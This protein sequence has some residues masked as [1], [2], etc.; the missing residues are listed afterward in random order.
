M[1]ETKGMTKDEYRQQW[2]TLKARIRYKEASIAQWKRHLEDG[3]FP[4]QVPTFKPYPKLDTPNS[5]AIVNAACH[6]A[7]KTI[8]MEML[9]C[10]ECKL[11]QD[12]GDLETLVKERREQR[13]QERLKTKKGDSV[14][15]QLQQQ[16]KELQA[17]FD[18]S[19]K[20]GCPWAIEQTLVM[21]NKH[22][23]GWC[24]TLDFTLLLLWLK[25]RVDA[26]KQPYSK[27]LENFVLC[28][29]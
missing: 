12:Y 17:K 26:T 11:A 10:T 13:K 23:I 29:L 8:L 3:T 14:V 1:T 2:M 22:F 15:L 21:I 18:L 6:Q 16:L 9:R 28:T 4:S 20:K 19:Q 27:I 7:R 24:L 5:Q 25:T